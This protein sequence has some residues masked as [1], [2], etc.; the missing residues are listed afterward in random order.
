M[1]PYF[2]KPREKVDTAAYYKVLRYTVLPWLKSTYPSGNYTWIQDGAPCH[3]SVKVQD[4]CRANLAD[5]WPTDMWPTSWRVM[6]AR[7]LTQTSLTSLQQAI[8]EA[9]DNLTEEYIKKSFA[10]V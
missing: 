9:W 5:F 7:H 8:V 2:F 1:P 3:T 10:S 4:L 6:P